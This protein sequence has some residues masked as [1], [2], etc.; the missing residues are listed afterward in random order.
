MTP[1]IPNFQMNDSKLD[2]VLVL[3]GTEYLVEDFN[4]SFHQEHDYKGEPQTEMRGGRITVTLSQTVPQDI[5]DWAIKPTIQRSG[6]LKFKKETGNAPL[7]IQFFNAY[8]FG[9]ERQMDLI[10][11]IKT[12]LMISPERLLLNDVE[13]ENF[14]TE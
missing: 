12:I 7:R 5:S 9:L 4:V 8:C 6:E 3:D 13:H 2:L 11:G 1:Q 14:W 10:R